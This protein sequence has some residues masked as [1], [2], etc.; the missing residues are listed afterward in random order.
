MRAL[1][2]AALQGD[3]G[4]ACT[5][6]GAVDSLARFLIIHQ[7]GRASIP[8]FPALVILHDGLDTAMA[9]QRHGVPE[10]D[11]LLAGLRHKSGAQRVCGEPAEWLIGQLCAAPDNIA[12]RIGA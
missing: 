7:A 10:A 11:S 2:A 4:L 8:N 6:P 3:V 5:A 12:N 1:R 9:G